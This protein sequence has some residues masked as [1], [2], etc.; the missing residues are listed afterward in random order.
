[1]FSEKDSKPTE[2]FSGWK[3]GKM[4]SM[5]FWVLFNIYI[6]DLDERIESTLSKF[7]DGTKLGGVTDMQ[8]GMCYYSTRPE[9]TGELGR[10]E[11]DEVSQEQV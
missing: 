4:E 8:E 10:E 9:Q 11:P 5:L 6:S 7:A 2:T 3:L 1:M